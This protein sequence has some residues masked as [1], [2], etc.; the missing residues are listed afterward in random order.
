MP[1]CILATVA[2][3]MNKI[4]VSGDT[5]AT[6]VDILGFSSYSAMKS[7]SLTVR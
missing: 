5:L 6:K 3:L 1:V 7:A 2:Q 4:Y